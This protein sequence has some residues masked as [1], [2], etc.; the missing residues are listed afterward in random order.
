[1]KPVFGSKLKTREQITN[2]DSVCVNQNAEFIKEGSKSRKGRKNKDVNKH[3][4]SA[5]DIYRLF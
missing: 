4:D 3:Q 1:M 5:T 2:I